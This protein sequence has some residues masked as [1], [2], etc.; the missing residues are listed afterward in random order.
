MMTSSEVAEL[1]DV[2]TTVLLLFVVVSFVLLSLTVVISVPFVIVG[3]FIEVFEV[4][5]SVDI[6]EVFAAVASEKVGG[7]EAVLSIGMTG[8]E[9]G[10]GVI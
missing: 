10:G 3:V 7:L 5:V 2:F 4:Y 1:K 8:E 9:V 6:V